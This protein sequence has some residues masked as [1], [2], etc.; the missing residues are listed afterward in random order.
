MRT[1]FFLIPIFLLRTSLLAQVNC[2]LQPPVIKMDFGSSQQTSRDFHISYNYSEVDNYCPDD[3]HYAVVPSTQEC[4]RHWITLP[5]DHTPGDLDGNMMLVN[6][7]YEPGLFLAAPLRGLMP[8]TVY[9]LSAW[10]LN[11]CKPES[12]CTSL[13]PNLVFIIETSDGKQIAK[14]STGEL[15]AKGTTAWMM[16]SAMFTTPASTGTLTLKIEDITEG[17]CGNDFALDDIALRECKLILPPAKK[18][19]PKK[20]A[21]VSKPVVKRLPTVAPPLKKVIP[22]ATDKTA[23][24]PVVKK[25]ISREIKPV[26]IPPAISTRANPVV[27][28]IEAPAGEMVIDLYDNGEIDGDTVSIYQNNVLIVSRAGLSE[29][30]VTVHI[31]IDAA[32]PHY[33]LVMVANNLGSIPPNTSLMIITAPDK[34]YEVFI[35][36]SEQKNAKV[37]IDLKS[38]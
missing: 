3:G 11:V 25:T 13:L 4:F 34:R 31:R 26:A 2:V 33:E 14:F 29:K 37:V 10:L 32:H 6:G 23:D 36:S 19:P 12:E 38:P 22:V 20:P 9:E 1:L 15:P 16:Y 21:V 18:E 8:N 5:E 28:Q 30:P 7:S 35:S 24:S 27:K 17:G